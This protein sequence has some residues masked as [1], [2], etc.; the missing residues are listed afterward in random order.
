MICRYCE[1]SV[2]GV[3]AAGMLYFGNPNEGGKR[4]NYSIHSSADGGLTWKSRAGWDVWG[5]GAA[6][7]DLSMTKGGEVGFVFERGPNDRDPYG[8]VSYGKVTTGTD[9]V[10]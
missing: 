4:A 10:L 9:E 8:W 6:Y 2:V 5:G 7:S 1:A 3:P